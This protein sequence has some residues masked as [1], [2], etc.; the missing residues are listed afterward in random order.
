M[1]CLVVLPLILSSAK[2]AFLPKAFGLSGLLLAIIKRTQLR[3]RAE[4]LIGGR[5]RSGVSGSDFNSQAVIL[6][7]AMYLMSSGPSLA[8]FG[9]NFAMSSRLA[10]L[11]TR[12]RI[13][14]MVVS[15]T[16]KYSSRSFL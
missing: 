8:I 11:A 7:L 10:P 16:V 2:D 3:K 9:T 5:A 15:S 6:V 1:Q 4:E 13:S 12:E 14:S